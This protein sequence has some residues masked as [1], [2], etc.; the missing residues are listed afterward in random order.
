MKY[1][2]S[3]QDQGS[4]PTPAVAFFMPTV[5]AYVALDA[6]HHV[7]PVFYNL[8]AEGGSDPARP[9]GDGYDIGDR[10]RH[11]FEGSSERNDGRAVSG[12]EEA[13]QVNAREH[14]ENAARRYIGSVPVSSVNAI[15]QEVLLECE[16]RADEFCRHY[17]GQGFVHLH[18]GV[19][20]IRHV[21][22]FGIPIPTREPY[23]TLRRRIAKV[24]AE[25]AEL[26]GFAGQSGWMR[27]E[28]G[29]QNESE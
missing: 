29:A 21:R 22:P 24:V 16:L 25:V 12:R 17:L 10:R 4:L 28:P 23:R 14:P 11:A 9:A 19:D 2:S 27:Q 7:D 3:S 20:D 18:R 8:P 6:P 15:A 13:L 26:E 5:E 1:Q